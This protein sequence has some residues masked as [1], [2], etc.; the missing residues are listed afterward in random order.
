MTRGLL[1]AVVLVAVVLPA[2]ATAAPPNVTPTL[3][4]PMGANGWY[5]GPVTINWTISADATN[6]ECKVAE[7]IATDT[8]GTSRTCTA[9]N[10]DGSNAK[11]VT[12]KIDQTAPINLVATPARPPDAPP[13]YTSPVAITWSAA[14]PT[15]GV[16]SCTALTYGGPDGQSAPQGACRDRAGNGTATLPLTFAYD[17]TAPALTGAAATA[18][19]D[20]T[21]AVNWAS[22]ADAQSVWV[23]RQPGGATLLDGAPA[24]TTHAVTDGPL[25][26]ATTYT[27]T[28]TLR[29]AAGHAT[30]AAATATTPAPANASAAGKAKLPTLRWK[31]RAG[32]SYYNVQL[33]R[34]GHKL[35]SAWP[36]SNHYTLK[37]RWRYRG[38]THKLAPGRY[39][40]YVW[41]GYGRRAAHRY[42]RLVAKGVVAQP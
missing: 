19:R 23:T 11:T 33:F 12:V 27:Y 15:S 17:A 39:R 41:P 42:G 7:T 2:T 40:W 3:S 34:S 20:R 21:V 16:A 1:I 26:P 9:S 28:I 31:R 35:L 22:D 10:A 4:G 13:F 37:A 32:A 29:D 24:A 5:V 18:R 14:D 30:T 36:A 25:A 8:A 6:A 38:R